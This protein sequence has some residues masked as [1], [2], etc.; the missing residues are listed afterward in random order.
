MEERVMEAMAW[1][2]MELE[3]LND[4]ITRQMTSGASSTVARVL[5]AKGAYVPRHSHVNEQVTM[6]LDGCLKFFFDEGQELLVKPGQVLVIPAHVPH[7]A[8]ALE[9]TI[10]IDFFTP[11]REDWINKEDSYLRTGEPAPGR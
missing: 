3:H 1:E 7:A 10:D 2:E 4:K 11:R 9:D 8:E 5:L 6:I